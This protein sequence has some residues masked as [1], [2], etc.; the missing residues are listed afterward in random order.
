INQ[1]AELF[2]NLEYAEAA[3]VT[4][5]MDLAKL[6]LVTSRDEEED[7]ADKGGTDSSNDTDA[8][9]VDDGPSRPV[10]TETP[11][12]IPRA[13]TLSPNSVLGKR[14]RDV[15]LRQPSVMDLDTPSSPNNDEFPTSSP[16]RLSSDSPPPLISPQSPPR[17]PEASGSGSYID[18]EMVDITSVKPPPLPPRKPTQKTDSEM[19]F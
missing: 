7:E 4:P 11:A 15:E 1:L 6:A 12:E 16:P 18:V 14:S 13:S 2:F 9:L 5:S 19:L 17:M 3:A 10:V 8:T